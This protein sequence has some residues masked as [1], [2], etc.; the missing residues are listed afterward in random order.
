MQQLADHLIEGFFLPRNVAALLALIYTTANILEQ[1][2]P[3]PQGLLSFPHDP[4]KAAI[5]LWKL[6]SASPPF[7][8]SV[9][10]EIVIDVSFHA[11]LMK[12]KLLNVMIPTG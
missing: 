1:L 11:N 12:M 3:L 2:K 4:D 9:S 7:E 5:S 6:R 8:D 10:D